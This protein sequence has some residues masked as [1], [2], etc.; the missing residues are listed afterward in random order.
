MLT[1]GMKVQDPASKSLAVIQRVSEKFP[2]YYEV[3]ITEP[4][5][6]HKLG[7]VLVWVIKS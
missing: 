6:H 1:I 4:R 7:D 5:S 3:K 2:D